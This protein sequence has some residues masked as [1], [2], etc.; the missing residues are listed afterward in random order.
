MV[1]LGAASFWEG[2][3]F[4]GAAL[5]VL[6]IARLPFPVP[7]DPVVAARSEQIEADGGDAFRDLMLPEAI[8][9]FRQGVGRLIRSADDRGVVVVADPR[10]ARSTYGARFLATLPARPVLEGSPEE[11]VGVAREWLVRE[12][13]ECPA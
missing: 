4:P 6:V 8:L 9:R 11:L 10:I 12:G 7:T 5:E 1:L 13:V 3:D 2:V